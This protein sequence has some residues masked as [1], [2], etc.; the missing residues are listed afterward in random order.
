MT[1]A[2]MVKNTPDTSPRMKLDRV[3]LRKANRGFLVTLVGST[4][5][6]VASVYLGLDY[7]VAVNGEAY[8]LSMFAVPL[9]GYLVELGRRW[10]SD[11][12]ASE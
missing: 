2:R 12:A 5:A 7:V 9:I 11:N 1:P 10:V 6:F 8:D 4:V 3:D